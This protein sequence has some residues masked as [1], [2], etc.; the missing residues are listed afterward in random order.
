M[1]SPSLA[2]AAWTIWPTVTFGIADRRLVEQ[3]DLLVEAIELALDDLVDDRGRLVLALHLAA[4][5]VALAVEDSAGTSS[6]RTYCG[7]AAA[8]CIAISFTSAWK[9]SVRATKSDSQ[10]TSTSTPIL[11][12]M[13]M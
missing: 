8:M 12:P 9:S 2:M 13:W 7:L 5:D 10:F 3:A 4:V 11:P 6:R 1:F